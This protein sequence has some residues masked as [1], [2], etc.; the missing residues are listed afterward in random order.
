MNLA[1]LINL[2]SKH[3]LRNSFVG[4]LSVGVVSL[5]GQ[6][7]GLD[8]APSSATRVFF[9]GDSLPIEKSGFFPYIMSGSGVPDKYL[10]E[11]WGGTGR[12]ESFACG[13]YESF[14]NMVWSGSWNFSGTDFSD[15]TTKQVTFTGEGCPYPA[16]PSN[17][18]VANMQVGLE[19][20]GFVSVFSPNATASSATSRAFVEAGPI[21]PPSSCIAGVQFETTNVTESLSNLFLDSDA[22]SR[23]EALAT[24]IAGADGRQF[25]NNWYPATAD[26]ANQLLADGTIGRTTPMVAHAEKMKFAAEF[27]PQSCSKDGTYLVTFYYQQRDIGG[28]ADEPYTIFTERVSFDDAPYRYPATGFMDFHVDI[29]LGRECTLEL[30]TIQ[31]TNA[32]SEFTP[33]SSNGGANSSVD[34][35]YYLG[36]L[37]DGTYVGSLAIK[38]D[39]VTQALYQ[40][41]ALQFLAVESSEVEKI[42]AGE[43]IRQV[44]A[45]EIFADVVEVDDHTFEVAFYLPSAVGVFDNTTGL[46]PLS[47]SPEVIYRV[48]NPDATPSGR[49]RF[50]EI[51]GSSTIE[52]IYDYSGSASDNV[53]TMTSGNGLR[54][55]QLVKSTDGDEI[56]ET[57]TIIDSQGRTVSVTR[58]IIKDFPFGEQVVQRILDPDGDALTTVYDYYDSEPNDGTSYGLLRSITEPS[59]SWTQYKYDAEGRVTEIFRQ[60]LNGGFIGGDN[61][62]RKTLY[63]YDD[64]P[65][66]PGMTRLETRVETLQA[67]EISRTYEAEFGTE[68]VNGS[69]VEIRW[70]IR[71]ASAGAAWDDTANLVTK[72][73][74]FVDGEFNGRTLS[75]L[76]PDGTLTTND[77]TN[78]G[79]YFTT[80]THDGASSV[81]G[82]AV[83]SGTRIVSVTTS[84][85]RMVSR[86][87]FDY[88]SNTLLTSEVATTSDEFGRPTRIDYLDGTYEIRNYACCG[89]DMITDR[90]GITTLF[91]Y[92]DLFQ[93][94]LET[95]AGISQRRELDPDGRV[96]SITR[97]G[98]DDS[99]I[100]T[101]S[102]AYDLAGRMISSGDGLNRQTFYDE[103]F[104]GSGQNVVT[105]TYPDGGVKVRTYAADG[106]LLSVSGDAAPQ[107]LAYEYGVGPDGSFTKEIRVG[108]G[109]ETTEWVTT[110]TDFLGRPYKQ[111]FADGA[112][113]LS[114]FNDLGQL[115]RTVD[116]DDVT[117]LFAYNAEGEQEVTAIDMN[118]NDAIDYAGTDRVT[119]TTVSVGQR[120]GYTV[121]RISTEVWETDSTDFATDVSLVETTPE[122]RRAWQTE[123][124]L[125]T[126][127]V[128]TLDGTGGW[129]VVS[130]APD[131]TVTTQ[132]YQDELLTSVD[133]AHASIG[134]LT[135]TTYGYDS[136]NRLETVTDARNGTTTMTYFDDDQL[137]TVTTP[138]PDPN[139][140]G[141]GYDAQVTSY[142]YDAAGRQD[143]VTEPDAS[144]V[145]TTYWPTGQVR[146]TWGSRTYPVEYAYDSQS[147]LKTMTT[148]QDFTGDTGTAITTWNYD[149]QRGF[150]ENKR[151][152]DN[153][154]PD[155]TYTDAGRLETRVWARGITTTYG[156]TAAGQLETTTYSDS[157]PTVTLGYDRSGRQLTR[158]DAAGTA[159]FGYHSTGRL[160]DETY[161]A[162]MF[163]GIVVDRTVDSL[164]RMT[165][166]DV[167]G[168][169]DVDYAY[170]AASRLETVTNGDNTAGYTYHPNSTLVDTVTFQNSGST[171]LTTAKAYDYLNRVETVVNTPSA[172]S[173]QSFDY[174][175]NSAN[176]RTKVTHA[177]GTY[178]EYGYDALG[179]VTSGVKR[180]ANGD[181]MLGHDYG[182]QYDD[183]GNRVGT[184]TNGLSA[185]YTPNSLNQYDQR[186]VPS[187]VEALG[188]A[189]ATTEILLNG[190]TALRQGESWYYQQ[191]V[192]NSGYPAWLDLLITGAETGAGPQGADATSSEVRSAFL[193]QTPE[194]Y[195]YDADGNLTQDGQWIY[196]WNGENRLIA[197]QTR[198]DVVPPIGPMPLYERKRLEFT[199][200]GQGRRIEKKVYS[201]SGIDWT[202]ITWIRFL[203]DGWNMVVEEDGPIFNS[204]KGTYVWGL[205]LSGT[206]QAAGGTGG[207]LFAETRNLGINLSAFDGVGNITSLINSESGTTSN[208]YD[209]DPYGN[210]VAGREKGDDSVVLGF[211]SNY[212]DPETDLVYF[213]LRYYIPSV[214]RWSRRDPIDE[215][216]SLNLN[217]FVYNSPIEFFDILGMIPTRR[218]LEGMSIRSRGY[219]LSKNYT[220]INPNSEFNYDWSELVKELILDQAAVSGSFGTGYTFPAGPAVINLGV[221]GEF[222]AFKCKDGSGVVRKMFEASAKLE[223]KGGV[224][225]G[226][227]IK[228]FPQP[229]G[230]DRNK[231]D[232]TTGQKLKKLAGQPLP[233][234]QQRSNSGSIGSTLQN[235]GNG[236]LCPAP[237]FG[238][239]VGLGFY[240]EAGVVVTGEAQARLDWDVRSRFT[241]QNIE[242]RFETSLGITGGASAQV[243]VVG[244]GKITWIGFID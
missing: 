13:C 163:D 58:E 121:E 129:T 227:G 88:P 183:I 220:G 171:R 160:E 113:Q 65:S 155:Y 122:G 185:T 64:A 104:D 165:G 93:I 130:T 109:G 234:R 146:R 133:V 152:A 86:D 49:V 50:S 53:M 81:D 224:G 30:V 221:N 213:G 103:A 225:T 110:F 37:S 208:F 10:S 29:E 26:Q 18:T 131:G 33:G 191:A 127:I 87:V 106:T 153:Q 175:Y 32:C 34:M 205:D 209:Y 139:R 135:S 145:Y 187:F 68:T 157:T 180:L 202:L 98:S 193:A 232:P 147:R 73:R 21:V 12:A 45:P 134:S 132:T 3:S 170:D 151:Y 60:F 244:A 36:N 43:A 79:T 120:D 94:D 218:E 78:N 56:T 95:R 237:G 91:G 41:T 136:H 7:C 44:K 114:Y 38:S 66:A 24:P 243:G 99:E 199:Y 20:D 90:Q 75:E 231:I 40:P 19:S 47:G 217:S 162:G 190:Q 240:G 203:Y 85:G 169:Y 188:T 207:L 2:P 80:V 228:R 128:T 22:R 74:V 4:F 176:Q 195:T 48:E 31:N 1:R 96:L 235:S 137:S 5:H 6:S 116:P 197:I 112:V 97:I 166:L 150:L 172:D 108:D 123:R 51:R 201:W 71:A 15:S 67:Q 216:G 239:I 70:E 100:V 27:S 35:Q 154:G 156:Y 233:W 192:D 101:E 46:Y 212:K 198:Q 77:Y 140:S 83:V 76:R 184:T 115:E 52:T 206:M 222:K 164:A 17:E 141:D 182:Y 11:S 223:V 57:R 242:G 167:A 186:E 63:T 14:S 61:A 117:T 118:G 107:Q 124:G 177:D 241:W 214:G 72:R 125:P 142:G 54:V 55:E 16:G 181:A 89:L 42:M 204:P 168:M 210:Q 236:C 215:D 82:T 84:T 211:S 23:G 25:W 178:W 138:D 189:A 28:G 196:T 148:W 219:Q 200:D 158:T 143:Q 174:T 8:G 126:T 230:R 69:T 59:G 229:K 39:V 105:T 144:I 102:R 179:Q 62:N 159:T 92:N 194:I 238:G 149:S 226:F 173:V 9:E 111:E 161:S 119:R